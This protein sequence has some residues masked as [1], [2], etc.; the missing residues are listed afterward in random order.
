MCIAIAMA[1]VLHFVALVWSV[2]GYEVCH[3][4]KVQPGTLV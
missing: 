3:E 1:D 4:L 2:L